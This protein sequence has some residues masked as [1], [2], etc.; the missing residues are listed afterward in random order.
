M[1]KKKKILKK[2]RKIE[3]EVNRILIPQNLETLKNIF[4]E[5][6]DKMWN[7]F[8][9][10]IKQ[11]YKHQGLQKYGNKDPIVVLKDNVDIFY[12]TEINN[13]KKQIV[14]L[15]FCFDYKELNEGIPDV[16]FSDEEIILA[17]LLES[18]NKKIN[19]I[20]EEFIGLDSNKLKQIIIQRF[21]TKI[22]IT[23]FTKEENKDL[24]KDLY[25]SKYDNDFFDIEIDFKND[26]ENKIENSLKDIEIKKRN[27]IIKDLVISTI[28]NNFIE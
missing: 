13:F 15:F 6:L 2:N 22:C 4:L 26:I 28:E 16:S 9:F 3:K 21:I 27:Q 17:K 20:I 19:K 8:I 23:N 24:I 1:K 5:S 7:N 14:E 25:Q 11:Y 12:E 18:N 10:N